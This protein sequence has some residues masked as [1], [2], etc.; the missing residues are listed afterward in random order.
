MSQR[1]LVGEGALAMRALE[2]TD[3]E[4]MSLY[5]LLE[6][7]ASAEGAAAAFI[8]TLADAHY[9]ATV[10]NALETIKSIGTINALRTRRGN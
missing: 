9:K 2:R 7:I 5:M 10:E 4:V 1:V 3:M 8:R 6:V